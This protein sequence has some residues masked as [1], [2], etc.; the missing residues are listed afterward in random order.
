[1]SAWSHETLAQR[2]DADE[3]RYS[4]ADS[5]FSILGEQY[6]KSARELFA[7]RS[8]VFDIAEDD[9]SDA[10]FDLRP[11]AMET[12]SARLAQMSGRSPLPCGEIRSDQ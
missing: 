6:L 11:R 12:V 10:E 8:A 1:M 9:A 5:P 3:V 4:C 2:P 7:A